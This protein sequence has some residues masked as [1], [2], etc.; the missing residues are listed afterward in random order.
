MSKVTW[1]ICAL[2]LATFLYLPLHA[3]EEGKNNVQQTRSQKVRGDREKVLSDGYWIYND[4]EKGLA[5]SKK[6]GKPLLIV[7]RCI[8]CEECVKLDEEIMEKDPELRQLMD[9]YVRVRIVGTNGLDLNLFQYDY[10]QSF[11]VFLMNADKTI[12]GRFGT[13]S[14]RTDWTSDVSID[15]F[16]KALAT[17]LEWHANYPENK[18]M[19]AAK[20]GGKPLFAAPEKSPALKDKY[21]SALNYEGDVV[22]SCIHCHQIGDAQKSFFRDQGNVIPDQYLFP[23]PHPKAIG[24]ILDPS[25]TNLVE[26]ITADSIAEKAGLKPGDRIASLDGQPILSIAD[27]QWVLHHADSAD[28]ID[29]TYVRGSEKG[30]TILSLPE[31]W[32]QQ[33]DLSWRVSSWPMRRMVLGGLVLEEANAEQRAQAGITDPN[34]MALRVRFMG[35]YGDHALAMKTG[36][37]VDDILIGYDGHTDLMRETDLLAYAAQNCLPGE[38]VAIEFVRGGAKK[39]LSLKM[40]K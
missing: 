40:Q 10:D 8:P 19:F 20:Q 29:V 11:A 22:K 2:T 28:E 39:K 15:G 33:D 26:A 23:Y 14:H 12:Y 34:Q 31:G 9:Q 37:Q 13:R 32:R 27:A 25:E 1:S 30:E 4:F 21:T 17:G 38:K 5:E 36:F 16:E 6:T 18:A 7:L 3:A 24:L 35:R